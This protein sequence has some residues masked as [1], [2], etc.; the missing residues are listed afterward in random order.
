LQEVI[1]AGKKKP[2]AVQNNLETW[3]NR[4]RC[5][6]HEVTHLT[7]FMNTPG[8]GPNVE[9]LTIKF[10]EGRFTQTDQAYGPYNV[11]L[12]RN[13]V[14]KGMGGFYTQRNGNVILRMDH[15]LL[16]W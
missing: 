6:F 2:E 12:L 7:C 3:N 11:K 5:F 9:D 16:E 14:K 8:Q 13:Y 1:D 4:A 15:P 10:K